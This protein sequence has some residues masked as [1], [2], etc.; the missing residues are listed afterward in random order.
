MIEPRHIPLIQQHGPAVEHDIVCWVCERKPAVYD[1]NAN[2]FLPCWGCGRSLGG[3]VYRVKSLLLRKF[4][5]RCV[6]S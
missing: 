6:Y 5:D 3:K 1:M 4:L 2:V